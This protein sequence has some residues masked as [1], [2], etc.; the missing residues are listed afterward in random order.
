[1]SETIYT[2]HDGTE[3]IQ[4]SYGIHQ[5]NAKPF[6]YDDKYCAIYDD[7]ERERKS[8]TLQAARLGFIIG[9][10]GNV[11][12]SILDYG[13]G[14]FAFL[15]TAKKRIDN[16]YGYDIADYP[17]PDGINKTTKLYAGY[18]VI[19]FHDALEHVEEPEFVKGLNANMLVVSLPNRMNTPTN[20]FYSELESEE[21]RV[22][23][24]KD[25]FHRKPDEHLHHYNPLELE[26]FMKS[27]DWHLVA[28]GSHEDLIRERGS[29]NIISM[30]FKRK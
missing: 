28:T 8:Q 19:S 7:P 6:V 14:N 11:P 26:L 13:C 1:M 5:V 9:A 15:K 4:D 21:Y 25:Y 22:W 29:W 20:G 23:F 30:A 2:M 3:Y 16:V 24:S 18:S 17:V 12:R 10:H 27:C